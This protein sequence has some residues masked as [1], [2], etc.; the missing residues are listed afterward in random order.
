M[1]LFLFFAI[2][3]LF[4]GCDIRER[5]QALQKREIALNE[6]E[7]QLLLKEKKLQLQEENLLLKE[8]EID[9]TL[10]TDS[11]HRMY[12]PALP[13]QWDVT[14]TCVETTCAGSAI[15]DTKKEQWTILYEGG[16]ILAKAMSNNQLTRVYSGTY[17]NNSLELVANSQDTI[18]TPAT[19][20]TVRLQTVSATSMEGQREIVRKDDCR[21]VYDL[22]LTKK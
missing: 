20:I 21:I 19:K 22:Q 13:G 2:L 7:Q 5:E 15:G 17:L 12:N 4:S 3:F 18:A 8:K 11:L 6:K 9:S 10:S 1:K 14:M 16:N